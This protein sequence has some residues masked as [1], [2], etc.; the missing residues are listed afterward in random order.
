MPDGSPLQV[1]LLQPR[2]APR[3]RGDAGS[4]S[5][6]LIAGQARELLESQGQECGLWGERISKQQD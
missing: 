3:P 4:C 1:T 5:L 2:P 6:G